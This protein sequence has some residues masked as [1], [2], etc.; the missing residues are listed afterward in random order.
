MAALKLSVEVEN[1]IHAMG[2]SSLEIFHKHA[3]K[4]DLISFLWSIIIAAATAADMLL[5][6]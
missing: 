3:F 4:Y 2:S 6:E 1:N 5:Q